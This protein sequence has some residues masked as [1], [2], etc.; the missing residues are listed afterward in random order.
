MK[1][2][3]LAEL[4]ISLKDTVLKSHLIVSNSKCR[5]SRS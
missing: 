2:S 4:S 3:D 1:N 5:V